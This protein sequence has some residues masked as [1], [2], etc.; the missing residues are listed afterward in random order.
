MYVKKCQSVGRVYRSLKRPLIRF[1]SSTL[2]TVLS[3]ILLAQSIGG[4]SSSEISAA[5]IAA[6]KVT[7]GGILCSKT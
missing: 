7:K 1:K 5:S 2:A 3:V 6:P 4:K